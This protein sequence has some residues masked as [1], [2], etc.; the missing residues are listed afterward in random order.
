MVNSSLF[1]LRFNG[2]NKAKGNDCKEDGF[3]EEINEEME[4]NQEEIIKNKEEIF[5]DVSA[6]QKHK[7]QISLKKEDKEL[8]KNNTKNN[9]SLHESLKTEI[10]VQTQSKIERKSED[11]S[12][13]KKPINLNISQ[14]DESNQKEKNEAHDIQNN[15]KKE[16]KEK[17]E[18]I[19]II[20]EGK[21]KE[22]TMKNEIK[23]IIMPNN[24][25]ISLNN[26]SRKEVKE[27]KEKKPIPNPKVDENKKVI[28]KIE[29]KPEKP[30]KTNENVEVISKSS[31][32]LKVKISEEEKQKKKNTNS[33][34]KLIV[35][36]EIFVQLKNEK[37]FAK[38]AQGQKLGQGFFFF[39]Y[40]NHQ[41]KSFA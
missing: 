15:Y 38:Y 19:L 21:K 41:T 29:K 23:E 16:E 2:L 35:G 3:I 37:I 24:Q 6:E 31:L 10:V 34:D 36:P 17:N 33:M 13:M 25:K 9:F 32:D 7:S 27:E 5:L 22:T 12:E 11:F 28:E 40:K 18:E 20:K 26:D 39:L 8:Y 14:N 1:F 30:L 4:K